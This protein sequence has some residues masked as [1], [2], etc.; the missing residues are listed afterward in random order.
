MRDVPAGAVSDEEAPRAIGVRRENRGVVLLEEF[1]GVE[2]VVVLGGV[3][4]LRREAVV[5]GDDVSRQFSGESPANAVVLVIVGAEESEASAVEEDHDGDAVA[6]DVW[7][8]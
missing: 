3:T 1:H 4:V 2:S 7:G 6:G 8:V 5:D